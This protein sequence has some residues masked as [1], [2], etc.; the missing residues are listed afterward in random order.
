MFWQERSSTRKATAQSSWRACVCDD[1]YYKLVNEAATDPCQKCPPGTREMRRRGHCTSFFIY[2]IHINT[3]THTHTHR[4]DMPGQRD[5]E[6]GGGRVQLDCGRARL[7]A[8]RLPIWVCCVQWPRILQRGGAAVFAL[9][10][11][12]RV[13][14]SAVCLMYA[15]RAWLLQIRSRDGAMYCLSGKHVPG[16]TRSKRARQLQELPGFHS[17]KSAFNET[18]HMNQQ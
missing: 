2:D 12:R 13:H 3:H 9:R 6:G 15:V 10:Q 16:G 4:P 1:I 14:D 11:G 7:P 8:A 17:E 18:Y 5:G